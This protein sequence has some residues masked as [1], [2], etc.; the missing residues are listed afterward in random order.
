MKEIVEAIQGLKNTFSSVGTPRSEDSYN[1]YEEYVEKFGSKPSHFS[2]YDRN[3]SYGDTYYFDKFKEILKERFDFEI[4]NTQLFYDFES[5]SLDEETYLLKNNIILNISVNKVKYV[6]NIEEIE[7]LDLQPDEFI[8]CSNYVLFNPKDEK[9]LENIDSIIKLF[10]D[11]KIN[12]DIK[13]TAIEMVSVSNS[14]FY[15]EDF[16]LK[17]D[18]VKFELPDEN[19]GKGF[20]DFHEKLI[21]RLKVNNKGLILLHGEP[22]TGKTQY[23]RK[24]IKDLSE[25]A[26]VLYFSPAMISSVTNPEFIDFITDWASESDDKRKRIIILEDAEPLLKT[27]KS[28]G[29]NGITNLLNLTSG[30]LS[31]ILSIQYICTFNTNIDEIDQALLREERLTAIK[32]FK[33][34]NKEQCIKLAKSIGLEDA[35]NNV[36][37]L[38]EIKNKEPKRKIDHLSLAEFYT[39]IN[40]N[41]ILRHGTETEKR[42]IG[43]KK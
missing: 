42:S 43:F 28:G 29:D 6:Y 22:G 24:L 35:E 7:K 37:K 25:V 20:S 27:R 15:A 39:I 18:F 16:Y 3:S 8:I 9:Y 38:I 34:L 40:K 41:E 13:R 31:D 2:L 36:S 11:C 1:V 21:N 4:L 10:K 19:Y 23:I 30:L 12:S 5:V 33:P 14:N 32:E 17:D 26:R